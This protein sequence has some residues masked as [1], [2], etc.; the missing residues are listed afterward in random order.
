MLL[1][2]LPLILTLKLNPEAFTYF[3]QLRQKHFPAAINYLDAHL[4]LFHHLP[5]IPELRH[6]TAMVAARQ[7]VIPLEI[8]KVIKLG[9]GVAYK[10]ESAGLLELQN[11]LKQQWL[12]WLT[13]Q[14]Q[15]RFNPHVTIQNKVEPST[16]NILFAELTQGFQP[17]KAAGIGLQLWEYRGGPWH[18][19]KD[20]PFISPS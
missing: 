13:P 17:F 1:G 6:L 16:A 12:T 5:N 7:P 18:L 15:Q 8:V 2:Q 19:V 11:Y 9:R 20:L 3:N 14:D 10:M 4:T